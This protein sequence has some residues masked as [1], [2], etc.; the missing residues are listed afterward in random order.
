MEGQRRWQEEGEEAGWMPES[1][2][3]VVVVLESLLLVAGVVDL[4]EVG[5]QT[6]G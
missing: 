2:V 3:V 6:V 1:E 4:V 5:L